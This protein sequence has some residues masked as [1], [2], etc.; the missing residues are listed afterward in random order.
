M[1]TTIKFMRQ[2]DT[3]TLKQRAMDVLNQ[4]LDKPDRLASLGLNSLYDEYLAAIQS[5]DDNFT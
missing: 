1:S 2:M 5:R 4:L 3:P